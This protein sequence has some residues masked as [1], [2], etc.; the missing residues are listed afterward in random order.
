MGRAPRRGVAALRT[1][2]QRAGGQRRPHTP[3]PRPF[4][5]ARRLAG[6]FGFLARYLVAPGEVLNPRRD[7]S[8]PD[9]AGAAGRAQGDEGRSG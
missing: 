8:Q 6:A 3:R 4:G 1:P 7:R 9:P 2:P 5:A